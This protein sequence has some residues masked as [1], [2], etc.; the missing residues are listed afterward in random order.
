MSPWF[1]IY[2]EGVMRELKGK[3]WEVG[4]KLYDE[5]RNWV[6]NTILFADDTVFIAE[7]E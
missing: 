4:V 1:S 7:N 2:V 6:L 3:V 5:G